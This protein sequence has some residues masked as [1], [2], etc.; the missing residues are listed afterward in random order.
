MDSIV[1]RPMTPC[2]VP[3]LCAG[4]ALCV[5]DNFFC[6]WLFTIYTVLCC[7]HL[8]WSDI[9]VLC[10]L[11]VHMVSASIV[12]SVGVNPSQHE[13]AGKTQKNSITDAP[14]GFRE[15]RLIK[16]R[17]VH[18]HLQTIVDKIGELEEKVEELIKRGSVFDSTSVHWT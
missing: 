16:E 9:K 7:A 17:T 12:A 1:R 2:G 13:E 3:G 10:P 5:H 14:A 15:L 11:A 18:V 6:V 8:C 4:E